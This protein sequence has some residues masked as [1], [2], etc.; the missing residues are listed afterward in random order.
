M[1]FNKK[2][3][4]IWEVEMSKRDYTKAIKSIYKN[5]SKIKPGDT[6]SFHHKDDEDILQFKI[7]KNA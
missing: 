6:I 7:R 1:N 5:L 3:Q 2:H 4:Q